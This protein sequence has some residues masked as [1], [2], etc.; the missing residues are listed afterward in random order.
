M[1]TRAHLLPRWLDEGFASYVEPD[2]RPHSGR[3]LAGLGMPLHGMTRTPAKPDDISIF[4]LKSESVVAYLIEEHGAD[5][6]RTFLD[7]LRRSRT[8]DAALTAA[9]G[10][11]T[12]GLE[13]RWAEWD[14]GF[15]GPPAQGQTL[16]PSSTS[17][18]GSSAA[19]FLLVMAV[20]T[21]RY[22]IGKLRN[23]DDPEEGLQ[24]WEDPDLIDRT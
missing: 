23:K 16:S 9:Y 8:V 18:S 15:N 14:G 4:Y 20:V 17:M 10:F 2:S 7:R 13:S 5:Q 11:D 22:I 21:I 6:F 24:P 1:G 12:R 3:A 19:C